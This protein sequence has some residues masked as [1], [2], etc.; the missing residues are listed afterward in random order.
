VVFK[1]YERIGQALLQ[2][3]YTVSTF[4]D[5]KALFEPTILLLPAMTVLAVYAVCRRLGL[6][7]GWSLLTAVT[8]ALLPGVATMHLDCFL[9]QS[10]GTPFLFLFPVA[11]DDLHRRPGWASLLRAAILLAAIISVYVEYLPILLACLALSL[12]LL[13]LCR[14]LSWR[15][16]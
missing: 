12:L 1:Q 2:A 14:R 10:L 8:A 5:A 13:L 9:A 7:P 15:L 6:A 3:F 4:K 11:L 16:T